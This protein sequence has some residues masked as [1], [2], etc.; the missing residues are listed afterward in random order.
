MV[1]HEKNGY[2]EFLAFE[3]LTVTPI[4]LTPVNFDLLGKEETA[5]IMEFNRRAEAL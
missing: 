1:S 5:W 4:D 3:T 2:G